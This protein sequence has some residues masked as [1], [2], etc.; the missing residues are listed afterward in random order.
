MTRLLGAIDP[1]TSWYIALAALGIA[2]MI[3]VPMALRVIREAKGEVEEE[4]G[5]EDDLMGPLAEAYASGQMSEEEYN[6]I[7]AT[8]LRGGVDPAT[9]A[10]IKP[11][12]PPARPRAENP[13]SGGDTL[14]GEA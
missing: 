12:A 8:I 2:L 5:S 6:R 4:G 10:R 3:G 7:K 11:S 14:T 9:F 1:N 13:G